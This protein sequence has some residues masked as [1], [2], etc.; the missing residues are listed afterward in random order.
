[1]FFE[2]EDQ[3]LGG[4]L[5][6]SDENDRIF[7]PQSREKKLI[8]ILWNRGVE[9][10]VFTADGIEVQLAQNQITTITYLQHE[11]LAKTNSSVTTFSFNREFYCIHTHD[12][13]VSCNGIIFFGAQEMPIITLETP[14][15]T[16]FDMLFQVFKEEFQTRDKIQGEM[17]QMLLKRLIIKVTRLAK[18]QISESPLNE[19]QVD[20]IRKFNGLVDIHYKEKKQVNDYAEL[21]FKSPKTLSNL[22]LKVGEKSPLSIIHERIVLEAKRQLL[23]TDKTVK[24]IAFELGFDEVASFHKMFKR[25]VHKTPQDFKVTSKGLSKV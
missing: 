16:S 2:Y 18:S 3:Q 21:L 22:F 11:R 6:L 14:E 15:A 13:E 10:F 23:Y 7:N 12:E 25:I 1:M 5:R 9:P 19:K 4:L 20:L 17:L 24:E 8:H